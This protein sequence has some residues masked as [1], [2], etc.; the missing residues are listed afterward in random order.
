MNMVR[1]LCSLPIWSSCAAKAAVMLANWPSPLVAFLATTTRFVP[2]ISPS[3]GCA[4]PRARSRSTQSGSLPP[5][6]AS[7]S[8]VVERLWPQPPA[9]GV[10]GSVTAVATGGQCPLPPV[11]VGGT[12][13]SVVERP[14]PPPPTVGSVTAMAAGGQCPL[15]PVVV[16]GASVSVVE[17]PPLPPS[18][19]SVA[20]VAGGRTPPPVVVGRA[21]EVPEVPPGAMMVA[22]SRHARTSDVEVAC[23]IA[24]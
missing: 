17:R 23:A 13:V 21:S 2:T 10:G 16:G 4:P 11:V 9:V 12:S 19:G 18:V 22:I 5:P 3:D 6:S 14:L 7:V 8:V 15:P 20:A 1:M 24:S